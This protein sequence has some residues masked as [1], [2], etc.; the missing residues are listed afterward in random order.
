V[1]ACYQN[2][3][4]FCHFRPPSDSDP[5]EKPWGAIVA[6]ICKLPVTWLDVNET[7]QAPPDPGPAP[8]AT[9][10]AEPPQIKDVAY[11]AAYALAGPHRCFP[12]CG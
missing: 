10:P 12:E 4:Q 11:Q 2:G 5:D 9:R 8:L 1:S 3:W 6:A 7:E